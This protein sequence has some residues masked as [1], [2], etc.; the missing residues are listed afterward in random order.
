MFFPNLSKFSGIITIETIIYNMQ[1]QEKILQ[2]KMK[3]STL[4]DI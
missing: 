4:S 1:K 2:K 3:I